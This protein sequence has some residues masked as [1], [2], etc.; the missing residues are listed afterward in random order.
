MEIACLWMIFWCFGFSVVK[1]ILVR[2]CDVVGPYCVSWVCLG[3]L[4][5]GG[6]CGGFVY[7]GN[8]MV[9]GWWFWLGWV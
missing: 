2:W 8:G 9:L 4:G 5:W 6:S 3:V 7:F 1:L